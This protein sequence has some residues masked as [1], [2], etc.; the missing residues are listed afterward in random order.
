MNVEKVLPITQSAPVISDTIAAEKLLSGE[1]V[2]NVWN[3]FSDAS[4]QFHVGHW[5]S[6][7]CK[8]EVSYTE[9]E[10]CLLLKGQA[11]LTDENGNSVT[12]NTGEPFLIQ[13]G[14]KGTWE[15]VGDVLKIY[16]VFEPNT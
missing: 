11:I 8:L 1:A 5:G 14:F 13:A 9:N 2:T 7:A 3:A 16:V 4:E 12:Y 6:K 10:F 15:S